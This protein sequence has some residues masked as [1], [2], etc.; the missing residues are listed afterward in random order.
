MTKVMIVDD[1]ILVRIGLRSTIHWED[2]G[3]TVTADAANGIQAIEKF[4]GAD[5][6]ILITDIR[7]PGMDGIEL[8]K[9]LKKKKPQL[10]IIIL[11]NYDNFEYAQQ[12]LAVGADDYLLKT[13][14]D[15]QTIFPVLQKLQ[16]LIHRE[17]EYSLEYQELQ[18][19]ALIGLVYLK[20]HFAESLLQGQISSDEWLQYLNQ[21][22][23]KWENN[24][25]QLVLVKNKTI[26]E[27]LSPINQQL[28]QFVEQI[29]EKIHNALV[30]ELTD[31]LGWVIIYNF[32]PQEE[33]NYCKQVIPFNIR[34]VK[35]CLK[36][37]LQITTVAIVGK[38]VS[39][40]KQLPG[41][42]QSMGKLME[43]CIFW[44]ERELISYEDIPAGNPPVFSLGFNERNLYQLVKHGDI[45]KVRDHLAEL[46]FK[47]NQ[48]L[49]PTMLR[50][51]W[52]E[53]LVT[54]F[55]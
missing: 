50:Q 37:Y 24:L 14:L 43:Y 20:K 12:A 8:I 46:F 13:T 30:W 32:P 5:P 11:T 41:E 27:N 34:Q 16:T 48:S 7:M 54:L 45:N 1:E 26:P 3:F 36:Q 15:N 55:R 33:S 39:D 28:L 52:H 49:S 38:P 21:L 31:T 6:D 29:V 9:T 51:V 47:V 40:F 19:K 42:W 18:Q 4:A 22:N 25:F 53:L 10:K 17:T 2:F 35:S 23:L 44:P